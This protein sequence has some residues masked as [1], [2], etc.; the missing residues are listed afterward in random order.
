MVKCTWLRLH[1]GALLEDIEAAFDDDYDD[2]QR[3]QFGMFKKL[4]IVKLQMQVA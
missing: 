3:L 4:V 2:R 1:Y